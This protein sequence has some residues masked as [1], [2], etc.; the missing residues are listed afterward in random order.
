MFTKSCNPALGFSQAGFGGTELRTCAR[1]FFL[2][3]VDDASSPDEVGIARLCLLLVT[4]RSGALRRSRDNGLYGTDSA[5]R[6]SV[7][8][9]VKGGGG[10][11][12]SI[13]GSCCFTVGGGMD[14]VIACFF[15][16]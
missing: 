14:I 9:R 1:L 6:V 16:L 15:V 11:S 4:G 2:W 8:T 10:N 3:D 12:S 7:R 13:S 5:L